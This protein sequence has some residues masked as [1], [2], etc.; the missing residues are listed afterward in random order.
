MSSRAALAPRPARPRPSLVRGALSGL[1]LRKLLGPRWGRERVVETER[2][3]IG[4]E[5]PAKL[6]R[7]RGI[8]GAFFS[9]FELSLEGTGSAHDEAGRL[10]ALHRP[11][12]V[13]GSAMGIVPGAWTALRNGER[14]L[15]SYVEG[16]PPRDP[17]VILKHIGIGFW[18]GFAPTGPERALDRAARLV[19]P[20][21]RLLLH[22]GLGF[23]TGFF[24]LPRA[25]RRWGMAAPPAAELDRCPEIRRLRKLDGSARASAMSGLGRSLWFFS[26]DRPGPALQ[27]ARALGPDADWVLGGI[28]LAAAYTFPDDLA[29]AYGAAELAAGWERTHLVKGIR[30]ALYARHE[31][32]AAALEDWLRSLRAPLRERAKLDL[33]TA[34]DVGSRTRGSADFIPAFHEGCLGQADRRG[35]P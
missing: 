7:I 6:E 20:A 23:K 11:F 34:L 28:G 1:L 33:E 5:D 32:D 10:D 25:F 3:R 8:L 21:Y 31:N 30:I 13:E 12:F 17:H 27:T 4:V 22:D 24:D 2:F 19:D 15:R 18:L 9:G 29:V 14:A 26:M 35:S 16:I